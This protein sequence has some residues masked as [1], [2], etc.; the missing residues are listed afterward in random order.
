[1]NIITWANDGAK[2]INNFIDMKLVVL[3]GVFL[4]LSAVKLFPM[5]MSLHVGWYLGL[6]I[7]FGIRPLYLFFIRR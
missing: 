4:A 5:I 1:M 6:F 2:R 7:L 3:M